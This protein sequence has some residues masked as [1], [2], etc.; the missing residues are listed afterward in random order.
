ML[1]FQLHL[2]KAEVEVM[3]WALRQFMDNASDQ[4]ALRDPF[5]TWVTFAAEHLRDTGRKAKG[6][7][8]SQIKVE[9]AIR[10]LAV[11]LAALDDHVENEEDEALVAAGVNLP[12]ARALCRWIKD[13]GPI[14]VDPL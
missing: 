7:R 3:R 10:E 2:D 5:A 9:I 13:N 12:V 4:N 11:I 8:K 1:R 6:Q 14:E